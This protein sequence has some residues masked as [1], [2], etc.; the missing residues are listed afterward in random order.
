M[1]PLTLAFVVYSAQVLLVVAVAE[2]AG[3]LC[4]AS[5][6]SVRLAYWRGVGVLCLALPLLAPTPTAQPAIS[7]ALAPATTTLAPAV[8]HDPVVV[9]LSAVLVWIWAGGL[10]VRLISLLGGAWRLRQLRRHSE[11]A[12]LDD[13][14]DALR[15]A[16]APRAEFRWSHQM[17]QPATFGMKRPVVLLPERFREL[18]GDARRAVACH[19]LMHVARRDWSWI[20]LEEIV[21]ALFW[22]HPGVWWLIDRLQLLREQVI[23]ER[24]VARL[25]ARR[26][27][28]MAL[29]TFAGSRR[30]TALSSSFLRRRQLKSRLEQLLKEDRMS[31]RRM[32]WTMIAV[33]V[34]MGGAAAAT[35]RALPL[36]LEA[37]AQD[38]STGSL[39]IR[40][41][42][43][44]PAA[45]LVEAVVSGSG[46]RIY[47]HTE[48]LAT[49]ADVTSARVIEIGAAQFGVGV[50]FSG[51]AAA[52]IA[53]GT[54]GHL[55]RPVAIVLDGQVVSAPTVKSAI[56]DSAV[57]TG[58][59]RAS[60]QSLAARLAPAA[61]QQGTTRDGVVLPVPIHQAKPQYTPAAMQAGIEGK[62]LLEAVVLAD[63]S[64]G[65]VRVIESLDRE[66]GLDQQAVDALKLWTWKPGTR[67][68]KP[69]QVAVQVQM[70]F[71]LK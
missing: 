14:I 49:A 35:A 13:D 24:V 11:P 40:L 31:F 9:S 66:F 12:V 57:I 69:A 36:D 22:F 64:S 53:S 58:V 68:G 47:L 1:D 30:A 46:Q 67:D 5:S 60:A 39:E 7:V 18:N 42:E 29:V 23:D 71:T 63:G 37:I 56:G 33:A 55:G 65:D 45:G 61:G 50:T 6:P 54:G 62:V 25:S 27:Y 4:R 48:T 70:T 32:A 44:A 16:M 17:E 19:E 3:L 34:V 2:S 41:A 21:R 59:T 38:R 20:V 8:W 26:E 43:S 28:M 10:F 15:I 52:R 51:P